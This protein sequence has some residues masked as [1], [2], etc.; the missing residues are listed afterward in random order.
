MVDYGHGPMLSYNSPSLASLSLLLH[1]CLHF[2]SD[3]QYLGPMSHDTTRVSCPL[4]TI[5]LASREQ[6]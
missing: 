2:H 3:T 6:Q 1:T 4:V 5:Q